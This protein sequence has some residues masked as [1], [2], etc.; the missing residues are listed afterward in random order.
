MVECC[1][2][3]LNLGVDKEG[4]FCSQYSSISNLEHV[5]SKYK[6]LSRLKKLVMRSDVGETILHI[7][8]EKSCEKKVDKYTDVIM[9]LNEHNLMNNNKY[10]L[11]IVDYK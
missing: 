9:L 4:L 7:G 3:C 11:F 10:G 1:E 2:N 8:N 5:C 6:G